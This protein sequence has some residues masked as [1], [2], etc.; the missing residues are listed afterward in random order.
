M[1]IIHPFT[2][3][4]ILLSLMTNH[5]YGLV[6][7][8]LF[9]F[10]HELSHVLTAK[11]F[12]IK[13]KE[14]IL[15]PTGF[16]AKIE[17]FTHLSCIKQFLIIIAGPLSFFVCFLIVKN[18]Y[19]FDVI[20]E[21]GKRLCNQYN[22]L[23]LL[24]NLLPC[25]PLDG[26]K[27]ID[28]GIAQIVDEFTCRVIR[29]IVSF[30]IIIGMIFIIKSLGDLMLFSFVLFAFISE[31]IHLKKNYILF[32]IKRKIIKCDY[33]IKL[34]KKAKI[35]RFRNN[36]MID[37]KKGILDEGEIIDKIIKKQ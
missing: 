16:K 3:I 17:D 11:F 30:F 23:I 27:I 7:L 31:L 33:K 2:I 14:I 8:Y 10:I 34:L 12:H 1:V 28:L 9:G 25:Y 21:Y 37:S 29:I 15:Y 26:G 13:T 18:L 32:L 36:Y 5:Y 22:L 20:S 24:F 6:F 4:Y 19:Y 35:Y